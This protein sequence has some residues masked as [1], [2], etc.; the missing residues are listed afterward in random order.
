MVVLIVSVG[1]TKRV[2]NDDRYIGICVDK[3]KYTILKIQAEYTPH[4]ILR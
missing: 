4:I 2:R 3:C 1:I